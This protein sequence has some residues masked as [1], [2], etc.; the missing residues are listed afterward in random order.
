MKNGTLIGER[1]VVDARQRPHARAAAPRRSARARSASYPCEP[2]RT[3]R[4]RR[5][6]LVEAEIGRPRDTPYDCTNSA[7]M[8]RKAVEPAICAPTSQ[9]RIGDGRPP[10][11]FAP[12]E[13]ST[14]EHVRRAPPR[15]PA[16][17]PAA[18]RQ[19]PRATAMNPTTVRVRREIDVLRLV[20]RNRERA[21]ER[22][23]PPRQHERGDAGERR[24]SRHPRSR[25]AASAAPRWRRAPRG[26][27]CRVRARPRAPAAGW[28]R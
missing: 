7:A 15:A 24:R 19:R 26:C 1:H 18:R 22:L 23:R 20:D 9:R 6:S 25:R 5:C 16:R 21:D 4:R 14:R 2:A 3:R 8:A 28:R 17:D 27:P 13:P 11:A 12:C 10:A